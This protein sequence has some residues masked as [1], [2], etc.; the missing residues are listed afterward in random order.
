MKVKEL[1]RS[2]FTSEQADAYKRFYCKTK[3][4][5]AF[6]QH[7]N[8]DVEKLKME[9]IQNLAKN[10]T[11]GDVIKLFKLF[12]EVPKKVLPEKVKI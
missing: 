7:L 10:F 5:Q 9:E 6:S 1:I 4:K 3:S 2:N 12:Y 11:N 8:K